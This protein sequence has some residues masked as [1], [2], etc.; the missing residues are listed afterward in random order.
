MEASTAALFLKVREGK[1]LSV[2]LSTA[3]LSPKKAFSEGEGSSFVVD[4]RAEGGRLTRLECTWDAGRS[5]AGCAG[6]GAAAWAVSVGPTLF[7]EVTAGVAF[8]VGVLV[9]VV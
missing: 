1:A 5:E 6:W 9:G 3:A 8:A 4:G 7:S 2:W